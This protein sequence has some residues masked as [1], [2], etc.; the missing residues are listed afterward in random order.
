VID[1]LQSIFREILDQDVEL[2]ANTVPAEL[3]G[4]DSFAHVNT[5]FAVEEHFGVQFSTREFGQIRTVG[6]LAELLQRKGAA[7]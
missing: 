2:D 4:W 5:L 1:E 7:A 3:P 6:D